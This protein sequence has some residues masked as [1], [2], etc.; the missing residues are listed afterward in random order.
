MT[1]KLV[2]F[3]LAIKGQLVEVKDK[4]GRLAGLKLKT[5]DGREYQII[6]NP[7]TKKMAREDQGRPLELQAVENRL[8]SSK[9]PLLVLDVK[10]YKFQDKK[11]PPA[12]QA[13]EEEIGGEEH[14]AQEEEAPEE[15]EAQAEEVK[16]AGEEP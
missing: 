15:E 12:T 1:K 2:L 7:S 9:N 6:L 3:F 8:G 13:A 14:S 11:S 10:S 5:D 16:E 4:Q